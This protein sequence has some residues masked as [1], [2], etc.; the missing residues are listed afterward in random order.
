[1][2]F[3]MRNERTRGRPKAARSNIMVTLPNAFYNTLK[4]FERRS[5]ELPGWCEDLGRRDLVTFLDQY[6]DC[7]FCAHTAPIPCALS[8]SRKSLRL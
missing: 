2:L 8:S 7:S 4:T 3:A 1:M 6:F 5:V